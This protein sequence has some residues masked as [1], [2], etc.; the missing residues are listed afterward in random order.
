MFHGDTIL[1]TIAHDLKSLDESGQ[2]VDTYTVYMAA[3]AWIL[4]NFGFSY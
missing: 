3:S 4:K 2:S 1:S